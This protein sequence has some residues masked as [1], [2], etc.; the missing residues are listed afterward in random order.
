MI[1]QLCHCLQQ[2]KLF[3]EQMA[4]PAPPELAV[5]AA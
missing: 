4:F 1:G 5:G 3:D 2:H